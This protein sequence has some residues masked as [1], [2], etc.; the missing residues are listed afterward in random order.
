MTIIYR[1][2]TENDISSL[3]TLFRLCFGE[4]AENGGA[5]SW[6]ENRYMLCIVDNEVVACTGILPVNKSDYN[7][8]EVTWTCTHPSHR[9]Q[10]HIVTM[11]QMCE[12]ELKDKLP[13]YCD[14]WHMWGKEY[15]NLHN[16]LTRVG[17]IKVIDTRIRRV[18][19][20]SKECA[21]CK[22]KKSGCMCSGDLYFKTLS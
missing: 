20:H 7:G 18:Y 17:F 14:C 19:P 13:V 1:K 12:A 8:Y 6:I 22:Y 5:L 21:G 15:A 9:H 10:G 4:L 16:A 2:S 3:K 11:L